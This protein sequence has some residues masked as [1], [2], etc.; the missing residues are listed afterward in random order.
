MEFAGGCSAADFPV[1]GKGY[2]GVVLIAYRGEER[3]AVKIR[4]TDSGRED[5]THEAEMLIAANELN[6]GPKFETVTKNFMLSQMISGGS[7]EKWLD[8]HR[9]KDIFR[10]VLNDVLEQCWRL[11]QANLYHRELS[12]A[13][14]HLL[15]SGGKP[16]IVDFETASI[17][18]KAGNVTS[19]CNYLF[20]GHT[21]LS[22]LVQNVFQGI[23][24]NGVIASLRRYKKERSRESF[25]ALLEVSSVKIS[26]QGQ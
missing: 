11:D 24:R 15:I 4:R 20:L 25:E 7:M 13:P 9:E 17:C 10:S 6:I 16:V 5:M 23:D 18:D 14:G 26:S 12:E 1:L 2:T 21:F 8:K 3:F 19:V 22:K